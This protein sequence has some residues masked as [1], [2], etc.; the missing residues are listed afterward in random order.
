MGN[1]Q[2]ILS[3]TE[4]SLFKDNNENYYWSTTNNKKKH[5]VIVLRTIIP[6]S[7]LPD[8]SRIYYMNESGQMIIEFM[9]VLESEREGKFPI[10]LMKSVMYNRRELYGHMITKELFYIKNIVHYH[11]VHGNK[12]YDFNVIHNVELSIILPFNPALYNVKR[13]NK[14]KLKSIPVKGNVRHT[15]NTIGTICEMYFKLK[16]KPSK[17]SDEYDE[18]PNPFVFVVD[19]DTMFVYKINKDQ[20]KVNKPIFIQSINSIKAFLPYSSHV[21]QETTPLDLESCIIINKTEEIIPLDGQ[22]HYPEAKLVKQNKQEKDKQ[23][24]SDNELYFQEI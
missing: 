6:L 1:S 9:K 4:G 16:K 24:A 15:S 12:T 21:L 22:I 11:I 13:I 20:I 7:K 5:S 23:D 19:S 14:N 18:E 17:L 10:S 3:F 2:Q 8:E